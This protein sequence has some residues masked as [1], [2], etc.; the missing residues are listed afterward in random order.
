MHSARQLDDTYYGY[1]TT[2]K[3]TSKHSPQHLGKTNRLTGVS[4]LERL[5]DWS[6]LGA[7]Q[8]LGQRQIGLHI[9]I[10]TAL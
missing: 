7:R 1:T 8:A 9:E 6:S 4:R 5:A 10:P 2:S 3:V